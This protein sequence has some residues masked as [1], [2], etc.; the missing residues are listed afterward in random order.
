MDPVR[1]ALVGCG[2]I[3]GAHVRAL[4][5]LWERDIKAIEVVAACDVVE[6]RAQERA[7]EL[8]EFQGTAPKVYAAI[9]D[10]LENAGDDVEAVDICS[11]PG[12]SAV[13]NSCGC[14]SSGLFPFNPTLYRSICSDPSRFWLK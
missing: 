2:G 9:D 8:G 13:F 3:A 12:T 5:R 10:L 4:S 11:Q 14:T 1:M 7:G 6:E